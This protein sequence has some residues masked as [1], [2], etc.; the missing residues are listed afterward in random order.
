MRPSG[1]HGWFDA[2]MVV[3]VKLLGLGS[4]MVRKSLKLCNRTFNH[5]SLEKKPLVLQLTYSLRYQD[6]FN[7]KVQS[8]AFLPEQKEEKKRGD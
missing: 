7:H 1:S 4:P 5:I 3:R 8:D 6:T 2:W